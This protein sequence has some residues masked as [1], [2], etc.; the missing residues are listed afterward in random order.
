M[1]STITKPAPPGEISVPAR[2]SVGKK[3]AVAAS[4]LVGLGFVIAHMIGN[5]HAFQGQK[6]LDRYGEGLRTLGEPLL[7]RSMLLW[8]LRIL[9]I[10]AVV[11]HVTF[12]VQ[13]AR[14]SRRARPVRYART[15]QVQ[16]TYAS[17][18]MRWGGAALFAFIVFHL[19]DL[20][21][22]VHPHFIRGAVYHNIVVGFRR[23]VV[24]GVYIVAIACLMLHVYHGV[25]STT[26]TLG[27]NQARWD[28]SIR[29]LALAVSLFL[30]I[31]FCSVPVAVVFH[32]VK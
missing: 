3:F 1:T 27:V 2:T 26:Q 22:G 9:L 30:F 19:M 23:P 29:R 6:Q 21:W 12:T 10:V 14:Q 24:T 31:G 7:P 8:A 18:T 13:L 17:R 11:V 25:W 4:G 16:A 32:V 20:S 5:L 15:G 28:R